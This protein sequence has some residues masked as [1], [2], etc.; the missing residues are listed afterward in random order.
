MY[1][2]QFLVEEGATPEQVDKALTDFG[3]AMGMF[4]V[5]D[6]AGIDVAC[7]RRGR[8]GTSP[9]R[10]AA[11][12]RP[13]RAGRDGPPRAENREGLVPL[14]RRPQAEAGSGGVDADSCEARDAGIPQRTITDEEIVERAIYALIN[15]GARVIEDGLAIRAS[16]IDMIYV[17]GY[18]FPA[19]RGGPM[20]YADRVGL[21]HD[22]RADRGVPARARRALDARAL[23]R[24]ARARGRH[25]PRRWIAAETRRRPLP[26]RSRLS[27]LEPR[28]GAAARRHRRRDDPDGADA[29]PVTARA[30]PVSRADHGSA[31][32]LGRACARANVPRR[33]AVPTAPGAV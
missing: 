15:E 23:A 20:F 13:R 9:A 12:A 33:S 29:G 25:V 4:A 19:W 6:M 31:R 26:R 10:R 3:M 1:E 11:S 32:P 17:N 21:A 18:G 24:A 14:R 28:A 30:R 27:A 22:L 7:A 16:D 5:D 2:T 8:S